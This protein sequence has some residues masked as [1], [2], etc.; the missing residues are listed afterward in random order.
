MQ[1]LPPADYALIE[2]LFADLAPLHGSVRAV[3]GGTAEGEVL[4]DSDTNPTLAILRGPEG[5]YVA[6]EPTPG[7]AAAAHEELDGWEYVIA[8]PRLDA[9]IGTLLPH[10]YMQPHQ[11]VR[12]AASPAN[13]PRPPLPAGYTYAPGDEPLAVNIMHGEQVVARCA[14]DL[15]IG[16]YAEIGIST[17]PDHRRKGLA[18]AAVRAALSAASAAGFTEIGWHCLAS[19]RGS[20]AVARAAGFVE[21]HRYRAY[22]EILPAENPGDLTPAACRMHAERLEPGVT[23]HVWLGFHVAGAWSQAG[24]TERALAAV[25]RLVTSGWQ[26]RAE[27]LEAHWSLAPLRTEP[28]FI[29]AVAAHRARTTQS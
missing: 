5:V 4:V 18:T 25:E 17:D 21:T 23:D 16:T 14:P 27:W 10:A 20:L 9:V 22:A 6:G 24:E 19:N 28:R 1:Q 26:G 13:A 8:D 11:R 12:L 29:A 3:L 7:A 2:P 15:A